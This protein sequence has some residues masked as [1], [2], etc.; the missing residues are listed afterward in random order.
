MTWGHAV[1]A[2]VCV[3]VKCIDLVSLGAADPFLACLNRTPIGGV[4]RSDLRNHT[5]IAGVI[6]LSLRSAMG[7]THALHGVTIAMWV[8]C[9]LPACFS[10]FLCWVFAPHVDPCWLHA[11]VLTG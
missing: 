4:I 9:E 3:W 5:P 8:P 6:R 2:Y 11:A 10:L 1:P 7:Q